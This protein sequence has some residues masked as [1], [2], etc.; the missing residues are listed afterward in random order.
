MVLLI[1]KIRS[2]S[3]GVDSSGTGIDEGVRLKLRGTGLD[4]D[5]ELEG[6]KK[7]EFIINTLFILYYRKNTLIPPVSPPTSHYASRL[8]CLDPYYYTIQT[9]GRDGDYLTY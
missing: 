1:M 5:R 8:C 2:E 4:G 9:W 3:S 6:K 7:H